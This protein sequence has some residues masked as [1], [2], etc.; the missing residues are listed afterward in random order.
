MEVTLRKDSVITLM[1]SK[2]YKTPPKTVY[3][4]KGKSDQEIV[5]VENLEFLLPIA[6][7][8]TLD[9][10]TLYLEMLRS[11]H[12]EQ[13]GQRRLD[14][15]EEEL[16]ELEAEI[17][18]LENG[19][20]AQRELA[21]RMIL[22]KGLL[23]ATKKE[24]LERVQRLNGT[25]QQFTKL[26]K[27]TSYNQA[28]Q[29]DSTLRVRTIKGRLPSEF[30]VIKEM[31]AFSL[32]LGSGL[33]KRLR[34][35]SLW[36]LKFDNHDVMKH[37]L[38]KFRTPLKVWQSVERYNVDDEL[39]YQSEQVEY[40]ILILTSV[41]DNASIYNPREN[42]HD[43]YVMK[44]TYQFSHPDQFH[45]WSLSPKGVRESKGFVFYPMSPQSLQHKTL[46]SGMDDLTKSITPTKRVGTNLLT[47]TFHFAFPPEVEIQ[48]VDDR[49]C[50]ES[51]V[52]L[53][54]RAPIVEKPIATGR[55]KVTKPPPP[56]VNRNSTKKR[57]FYSLSGEKG[58]LGNKP[59]KQQSLF[60][61]SSGE[62]AQRKAKLS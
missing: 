59:M 15:L 10:N 26:M 18:K 14:K 33:A 61:F 1:G 28:M 19:E 2:D 58:D 56:Q 6:I 17:V 11:Y 42:V 60:S 12:N 48:L 3:L 53:D 32:P 40:Q 54:T 31:S 46:F 45:S 4:T 62:P 7:P 49:L 29:R 36:K 44:Q 41:G 27:A 52:S 34:T 55:V 21:Q 51:V 5:I 20:P 25:L 9:P 43:E 22:R 50:R 37:Y 57:S 30:F 39:E 23:V 13:C 8:P 35:A 24:D 16:A 47:N 38:Q